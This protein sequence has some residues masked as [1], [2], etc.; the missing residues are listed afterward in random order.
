MDS[1]HPLEVA[2]VRVT[3]IVVAS[4]RHG[5]DDRRVLADRSRAAAAAAVS[6]FL[7]N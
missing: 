4:P 3:A 5:R 1:A 6:P 7:S 2:R